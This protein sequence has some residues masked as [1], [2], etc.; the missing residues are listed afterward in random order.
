[1]RTRLGLC[2]RARFAARSRQGIT[3]SVGPRH[4]A[5]PD[6][7]HSGA[8]PSPRI[9]QNTRPRKSPLGRQMS[10]ETMIANATPAL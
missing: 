7:F 5:T 3:C 4:A 6:S 2:A 10:I 8:R 1:M 9:L